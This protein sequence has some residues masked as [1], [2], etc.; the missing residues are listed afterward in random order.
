MD[1]HQKLE[2]LHESGPFDL[3]EPAERKKLAERMTVVSFEFGDTVFSV[4]DSGDSLYLVVSGHARVIG[5]DAS[6]REVSLALLGRAAHFGEESILSE[7]PRTATV[8]AAED[9]VVLRLARR[10]FVKVLEH[11]PDVRRSFE[12]YVTDIGIQRFLKQF[13]VLEAV[14]S[15]VLRDLLGNLEILPMTP[16]QIVIRQGDEGD[17]VYI[18]Q[19]GSLEIRRRTDVGEQAIGFLGPGEFFGVSALLRGRPR[20]ASVVAISEGQLCRLSREGFQKALQASPRLRERLE[21]VIAEQDERKTPVADTPKASETAAFG[22]TAGTTSVT[23][24]AW[25][26]LLDRPRT[27]SAIRGVAWRRVMR[28]FP[29]VAQHDQSDCGA[30]SLAMMTRYYGIA[31]GL[32]RLRDMANVDRDGASMWSLAKA[33]EQI[34]FHA[35]GLQVSCEA[36]SDVTLPAILHWEGYHYVV[37]YRLSATQAIIG[38]PAVGI[39]HLSMAAFR[40]GFSG[41]VLELIPTERLFR[42]DQARLSY[43]HFTAMARPHV[44]WIAGVVVASVVLNVLALGLPLFT[45][46]IVDTVLAQNRPNMLDLLFGGML[47]VAVCQAIATIV[48]HLLLIRIST[49]FDRDLVSTFL[50][51]V[52]A[53]PMRFFDLRRVGDVISRVSENEKVR[54]AIVGT[55]PGMFLD[56]CLAFGYFGLLGYYNVRYMLVV[57]VTIPFFLLLILLFTPAIRRNQREYFAKHA[58]QWSSLIESITGIGTIKSVAIEK[59]VQKKWEN[60]FVESLLVGARSARLESVY[61]ALALLLSAAASSLFLWYGAHQVLLSAMT[62]GQLIAMTAVVGNIV[63]PLLRLVESWGDLQDARNAV[64]RLNDVLDAEPEEDEK[65]AT[66]LVLPKLEGRIRFDGVSFRYAPGQARPTLANLSFEIEPGETVAVVGRSGSGKSTLAKLILGLYLPDEGSVLMD[67]HDMRILSR[68]AVRRRIGVVPQE[69]FLFSGSITENV[70]VGEEKPPIEKVMACCR[71][72]GAH[73]FI[74]DMGLGYDS[75]VGERGMCLSG[76]Q[77]Q[78]IALARALY[79]EP[80]I[81]ILD[82]ATSALDV[83]SERAIQRNL[84]EVRRGRTTLIIAHRLSTV[85]NAD[86]IIVLDRGALVETGT[87]A[88]L[89]EKGGLYAGLV[90]QQLS[91]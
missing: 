44:G 88:D 90:R 7:G 17:G 87:H 9:L 50:R 72:A 35:R 32:S 51:Y 27:Q 31:M 84:Q 20:S 58:D 1:I 48:R 67:G 3:L 43:R 49:R 34:G 41:R 38:D 66:R 83:E 80:D 79:H 14:P 53:L 25:Q 18:V 74:S 6:G 62:A 56:A 63:T 8:R 68:H 40:K 73:E 60:A 24:K 30:A 21:H 52:M 2:L 57:L 85:Q 42:N 46:Y 81:L 39:R 28:M 19:K 36:L 76:G 4:G 10:E 23:G 65:K 47:L 78:R 54:Q 61:I 45:Q 11:H 91:L 16:S 64:E 33:A 12:Q 82:E 13:T 5:V 86:R 69:V 71:L 22:E 70:A 55:L 59:L 29:F 26:E 37:L 89:L 77:R 15:S 75:K